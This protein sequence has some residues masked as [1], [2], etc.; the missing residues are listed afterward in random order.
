MSMFKFRYPNLIHQ[1]FFFRVCKECEE[2][3]AP[4]ENGER[5]CPKDGELIEGKFPDGSALREVM[6]L[7][8]H[9]TAQ[10]EVRPCI[11]HC[12]VFCCKSFLGI[13]YEHF[14]LVHNSEFFG[15][16]S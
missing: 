4:N 11:G 10:Q 12:E 7:E 6:N 15:S 9:C 13:Q 3:F 2:N 8:C 5:L 1:L 16:G 14:I